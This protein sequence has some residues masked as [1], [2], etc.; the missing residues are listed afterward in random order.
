[1]K[2]KVELTN[3]NGIEVDGDPGPP[4]PDYEIVDAD[5]G[6]SLTAPGQ[7]KTYEEVEAHIAARYPGC[8]RWAPLPAPPEEAAKVARIL[9]L[10]ESGMELDPVAMRRFLIG[11]VYQYSYPDET[12]A[13]LKAWIARLAAPAREWSQRGRGAGPS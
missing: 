1:M 13:K 3:W 5:T 8:E 4:E 11:R 7:L 9:E 2:L 10:L 6:K 12:V